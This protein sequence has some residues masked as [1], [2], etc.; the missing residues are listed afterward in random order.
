[1]VRLIGTV[2]LVIGCLAGQLHAQAPKKETATPAAEASKPEAAA[3]AQAKSDFPL[4]AF[5]QFSAIVF[6]NAM[7][8]DEN[9]EGSYIYRSGNL[10]R[11]EGPEKHGYF[12]TN[13][14][15]LETFGISSSPCVRDTHP[16]ILSSPFAAM[17]PGAKVKKTDGGQETFNGHACHIEHVTITYAK[18]SKPLELKLWEADDLQG[19]PIKIEFVRA[20]GKHNVVVLYK[21]VNL[22]PQDP[23]LF[24][25]PKSCDLLP[26]QDPKK[27]QSSPASKKPAA[28]AQ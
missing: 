3:A 8:S 2:V 26:Q 6:G 19:F 25:H 23:T 27:T 15:T 17:R 21:N 16:F 13:L 5:T 22:G 14:E 1:M 10:M 9:T 28:P 18:Q 24:I 12:T 4:D 7:G 20:G 11:M